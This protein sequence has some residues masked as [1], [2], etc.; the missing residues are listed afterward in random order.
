MTHGNL[1]SKR[2]S[3]Q[4]WPTCENCAHFYRCAEF[5]PEHEAFPHRWHWG[6]ESINLGDGSRLL[7]K[8]WVGTMAIA[9]PHTGCYQYTVKDSALLPLSQQHIRILYLNR[10]IE[11]KYQK[12]SGLSEEEADKMTHFWQSLD[13]LEQAYEEALNALK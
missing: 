13:E 11:E 7:V 3:N 10:A 9:Q 2:V 1:N 8:S 5:Q 6:I 12:V 4:F